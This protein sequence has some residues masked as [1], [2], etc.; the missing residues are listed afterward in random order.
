MANPPTEPA[1]PP[2][3]PWAPV[4]VG[5]LF[6][7]ASALIFAGVLYH[8]PAANSPDGTAPTTNPAP[9]SP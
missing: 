2:E 3:N 6:L 5:A 8:P 7:L 4:I 9:A 1:N